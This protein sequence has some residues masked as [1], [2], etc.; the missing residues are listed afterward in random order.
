[1]GAIGSDLD[2]ADQSDQ[3]RSNLFKRL[4]AKIVSNLARAFEQASLRCAVPNIITE[5]VEDLSLAR[6]EFAKSVEHYC[7][8]VAGWNSATS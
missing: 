4:G 8:K 1:L 7:F 5:R 6:K 3:D 2:A